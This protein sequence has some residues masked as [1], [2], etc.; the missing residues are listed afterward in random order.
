MIVVAIIDSLSYS[1]M[2]AAQATGKI[3]TYQSVVGSVMLITVPL[4][5]TFLKLGYPSQT[6]FYIAILNALLC[7]FLR[8]VLLRNMVKLSISNFAKKVLLPILL[9]SIVSYLLPLF[10]IKEM[11][12]GTPRFFIVMFGGLIPALVSIYGIGLSKNE[13]N[14][15]VQTIS[16]FRLFKS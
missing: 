1:L 4:A 7:L 2:A 14:Y 9:I 6:V 3:K 12:Y 5:Y 10:V 15:I 11:H 16:N 13:R 8:L